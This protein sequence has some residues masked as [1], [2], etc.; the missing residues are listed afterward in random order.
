MAGT[1]PMMITSQLDSMCTPEE[2]R[3]LVFGGG[4]MALALV[5]GMVN[6]GYLND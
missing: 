4:K 1:E 3:L 6:A 2:R 5:Q